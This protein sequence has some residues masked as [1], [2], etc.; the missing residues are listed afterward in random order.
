MQPDQD[1]DCSVN[2]AREISV[3]PKVGVSRSSKTFRSLLANVPRF[4]A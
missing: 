1:L 2:S 3:G 4:V